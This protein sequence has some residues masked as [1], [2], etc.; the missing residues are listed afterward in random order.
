MRFIFLVRALGH[1]W[2][3]KRVRI[4]NHSVIQRHTFYVFQGRGMMLIKRK[5]QKN[6]HFSCLRFRFNFLFQFLLFQL[7]QFCPDREYMHISIC[8]EEVE[9]TWFQRGQVRE[10]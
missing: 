8:N 3:D 9:T 7:F 5:L 10:S 1:E 6:S 2:D 4:S